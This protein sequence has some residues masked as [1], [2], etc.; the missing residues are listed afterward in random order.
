M[1]VGV[2]TLVFMSER[3][4]RPI[5]LTVEPAL[6]EAA[7]GMLA[8]GDTLSVEGL[9]R[10]AG[11]TRPTFYRRYPSAA[12]LVSTVMVDRFGHI[13]VPDTG[14]VAGDVRAV[15]THWRDILS[16]PGSAAG[17][18]RVAA[19]HGQTGV[20]AAGM[21]KPWEDA[22]STV[23]RRVVE[24][25]Q[26]RPPSDPG[27]VVSLA[28][29]PLLIRSVVP[30]TTAADEKFLDM[31]TDTVVTAITGKALSGASDADAVAESAGDG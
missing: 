14:T 2:R 23:I 11:V 8:A 25:E 29:G 10:G 9:C 17:V 7:V 19:A 12:A 22:I 24:R 31:L 15:L 3:S 16:A 1:S 27:F 13:R 6:R 26:T 4:G 20:D 18:L 28:L 5:D 30:G 21:L